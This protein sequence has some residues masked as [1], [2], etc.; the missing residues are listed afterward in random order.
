[1]SDTEDKPLLA[2]TAVPETDD[3]PLHPP[4]PYV[5]VAAEVTERPV[6]AASVTDQPPPPPVKYSRSMPLPTY[7]QSEKYETEGVLDFHLKETEGD[8]TD[9]ETPPYSPG[10]G[11]TWCE[12]MLFF[13]IC[14][15]LSLVGFVFSICVA[16]TVAA[17]G[18]AVAGLGIAL[19]SK[20]IMFEVH[21]HKLTP[22][23]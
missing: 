6:A 2:E 9:E 17:K 18:G 12:F 11:G 13:A 10:T 16:T 8:E 19:V 21:T 7:A 22:L 3:V 5:P 14:S 15:M 1:M 20:P 23:L 4:P